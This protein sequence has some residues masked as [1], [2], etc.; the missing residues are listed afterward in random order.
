MLKKTTDKL[1]GAQ[2]FLNEKDYQ[3]IADQQESALHKTLEQ[4][5]RTLIILNLEFDHKIGL[6]TSKI[7]KKVALQF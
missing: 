5:N 3:Q 1:A 2:T 6:L 4:H 7:E